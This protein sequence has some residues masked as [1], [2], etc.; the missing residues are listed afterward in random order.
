MYIY[1]Y[2]YDD[3]SQCICTLYCVCVY[4]WEVLCVCGGNDQV[5]LSVSWGHCV[6]PFWKYKVVGSCLAKFF[7]TLTKFVEPRYGH[8]W[9]MVIIDK[10][11][12]FHELLV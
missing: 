3:D 5:R 4:V 8:F 12:T 6:D 9:W 7:H 2:T 10:Q 1:I 11:H